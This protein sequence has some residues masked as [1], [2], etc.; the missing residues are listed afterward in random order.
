METTRDE[1][2]R[3][4]YNAWIEKYPL[5]KPLTEANVYSLLNDYAS[6]TE[7]IIAT[8]NKLPAIKSNGYAVDYKML[9]TYLQNSISGNK[10]AIR[11]DQVAKIGYETDNHG[12]ITAYGQHRKMMDSEWQLPVIENFDPK[13]PQ[14]LTIQADY[15]FRTG[16]IGEQGYDWMMIGIKI[17][18]GE[19][20]LEDKLHVEIPVDKEIPF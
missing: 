3:I 4:V 7:Y 19:I 20:D 13:N 9:Q 16:Q 6:D 2:Y 18:S 15:L 1:A 17:I 10:K 14:H 11:K 12:N 5:G 8:T